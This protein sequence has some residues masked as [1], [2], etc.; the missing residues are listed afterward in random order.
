MSLPPAPPWTP[1]GAAR[2]LV[3][4]GAIYRDP[5]GRVLLVHPTYKPGWDVPGG[6]V[7]T[8][9]APAVACRREVLEELGLDH[10]PGPLLTVDWTD[11]GGHDKLLFLFDGG[12]LGDDEHRIV[13][14]ADELDAWAWVAPDDLA[15]HLPP[16]LAR[17][18]GS[19]VAGATGPYLEHGLP[20][21]SDAAG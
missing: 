21:R 9:E 3:A 14:Q 13:L 18:V 7:E 17:R 6:V 10:V 1:S 5:Q 20:V 11:V 15:D 19:T 2:P 4:A 16:P 8:G 12:L